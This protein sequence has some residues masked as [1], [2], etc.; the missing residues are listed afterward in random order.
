MSSSVTSALLPMFPE[1]AVDQGDPFLFEVP[2]VAG[3]DS[4]PYLLIVTSPGF[5]V[6]GCMDPLE[7]SSW[8]RLGDSFPGIGVDPWAWAPCVRFVAGLARPWVMLYSLAAGAGD[9]GGHQFHVIR[10]ADSVL[11]QGPYADTGHVLTSEVAFAIDPDVSVRADGRTWLTCASDH[12]DRPPFGTGLF[13]AQITE[14]LTRLLTPLVPAARATAPWQIYEAERSMPWIDLPGVRWAAG[15]TVTWYTMEGPA[16]L[17]SPKGRD[18]MLYSGG[19]FADFYAMGLLER[20]LDGNWR[21]LSLKPADCLLAPGDTVSGLG[22]GSY[23]GSY[24][25]FHF[26]PASGLRQFTVARIDWHE[27]ADLPY[28]SR[29]P[30]R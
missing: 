28:V 21:D 7:P 8:E 26:R 23:A 13:E 14:D 15:A 19:N 18:L 30:T 3:A 12:V 10:R 27:E 1:P 20:E 2:A 4:H 5:P 16:G 6:Y 24:L 9:P 17:L 11:P 25:A 29:L 22:H